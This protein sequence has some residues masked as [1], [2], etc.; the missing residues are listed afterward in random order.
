MA[1]TLGATHYALANTLRL[2]SG[3]G[4]L[5]MVLLEPSDSAER[6]PYNEIL[7]R[8]DT[9]QTLENFLLWSSNGDRNL[10]NTCVLDVRPF[11]SN[12]IRYQS[13]E[14]VRLGPGG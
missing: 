13:P 1:K 11:R 4:D 10:E 12:K 6:V 7:K 14:D 5:V 2:A 3:L 9:L 8:S